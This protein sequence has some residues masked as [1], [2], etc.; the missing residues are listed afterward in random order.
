MIYHNPIDLNQFENS[1]A[2]IAL[3]L[4][5]I[6]LIPTN[7][8]RVF[9]DL[10]TSYPY[11]LI[12]NRRRDIGLACFFV[13]LGHVYL[14]LRQENFDFSNLETY[15]N[16]SSGILTLLLLSI[17]AFTSNNQSQ[18]KLRSNWKKLHHVVSYIGLFI[19]SWH[20]LDKM[21]KY[22]IYTLPGLILLGIIALMYSLRKDVELGF[23][24]PIKTKKDN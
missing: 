10:V 11:K 7:I 21:D 20:V 1:L 17:L 4:F 19:L 16:F 22:S 6:G 2:F 24:I 18:R 14:I 5:L 8:R 15:S 3:V 23:F 12:L 13:S 9:P